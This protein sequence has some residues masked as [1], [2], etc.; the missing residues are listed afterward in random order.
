MLPQMHHS[1]G[2]G[3]I[4]PMGNYAKLGTNTWPGKG[5]VPNMPPN[6]AGRQYV[7]KGEIIPEQDYPAH[8]EPS[9][10]APPRYGH[11][12]TCVPHS[13]SMYPPGTLPLSYP[14][15]NGRYYDQ[16]DN[17][18][19][20]HRAMPNQQYDREAVHSQQFSQRILEDQHV[21]DK[22]T[23]PSIEQY[24]D[25]LS[26]QAPSAADSCKDEVIESCPT[27]NNAEG[28][29]GSVQLVKDSGK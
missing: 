12:H 19:L 4:D 6:I 20:D 25:Q 13:Q 9:M 22:K 17:Q 10:W 16:M 29:K 27:S 7:N 21:I 5:M 23:L 3:Q 2:Q 18:A 11:V 28:D 15:Q 26:K 14:M 8:Y 24:D 1:F